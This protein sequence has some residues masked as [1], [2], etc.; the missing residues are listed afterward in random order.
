MLNN[1][2]VNIVISLILATLLWVYVV[3]EVQPDTTKMLRGVPITMTRTDGL[4]ERGL[5]ISAIS[6]ESMDVEISGSVLTLSEI[7]ASDVTASVDV[8]TAIRGENEMTVIVRVPSGITVTEKSI[9]RVNVAIENLATKTLDV[10]IAYTGTFANGDE[11]ETVS[12]SRTQVDVSG[13]ES[14]VNLVDNVRGNIDAARVGE[15]EAEVECELQALNKE[16]SVVNDLSFSQESVTVKT[17]LKRNKTVPLEVKVIDNSGEDVVHDVALPENVIIRGRVDLLKG[18]EKIEAEPLDVSNIMSNSEVDI[19]VKLPD[20]I[21]LAEG[22]PELKAEVTVT[23][24]ASKTLTFAPLEIEIEGEKSGLSYGFTDNQAVSVTLRDSKEIVS[25]LSKENIKLSVDVAN[26]QAS[27]VAQLV[28]V[29]VT[30]ESETTEI[31]LSPETVNI[32]VTNGANG[33][34]TDGS[35]NGSTNGTT[36]TVNDGTADTVNGTTDTTIEG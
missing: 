12:I 32:T 30:I 24:F 18:I 29:K 35:T 21:E 3:G 13:A 25:G 14:L 33:G 34:T 36:D 5:A 2:K 16:G 8:G 31:T 6:T 15:E 7:D 23:A 4:A 28:P 9:N 19:E 20:K 1:K 26:L 10:N 11:A 17:I 27:D 22:S